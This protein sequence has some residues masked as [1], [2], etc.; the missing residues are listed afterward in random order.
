MIHAMLTVIAFG[1]FA[2]LGLV[3]AA[4]LFNIMFGIFNAGKR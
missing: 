3:V 4:G 2:I 1:F